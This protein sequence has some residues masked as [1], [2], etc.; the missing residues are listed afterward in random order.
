MKRKIYKNKVG[1]NPIKKLGIPLWLGVVL[2]IM[3]I[4]TIALAVGAASKGAHLASLADQ[5]RVVNEENEVLTANTVSGASL[6]EVSLKAE[7]LGMVKADNVLYLVD[8]P[9][10]SLP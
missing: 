7:S 1:V 2:S 6:K 9:V 3:L 4:A 5:R 10:A 8:E